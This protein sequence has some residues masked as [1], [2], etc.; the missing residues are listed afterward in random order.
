MNYFLKMIIDKL[1]CKHTWNKV[2]TVRV[3]GHKGR[4]YSVFHYHCIFCGK[5]KKIKSS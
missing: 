4:K 3:E 5:I 2:E 1:C